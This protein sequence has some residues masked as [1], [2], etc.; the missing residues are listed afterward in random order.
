MG[1]VHTTQGLEFYYAGVIVGPDMRYEDGRIVTDFTKRAKTDASTL[2]LVGM[3]KK[4]PERA[5]KKAEQIVKNTYR[6]LMSRGVKGCYIYCVDPS[7]NEYMHKVVERY[8]E[9]KI[10]L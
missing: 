3:M 9:S 6:V 1:C 4:D 7:L 10:D 5:Q 8:N 2:G